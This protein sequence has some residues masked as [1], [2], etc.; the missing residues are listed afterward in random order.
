MLSWSMVVIRGDK[1]C[2]PRLPHC[3]QSQSGG[4]KVC[5]PYWLITGKAS[6]CSNPSAKK[7]ISVDPDSVSISP[8]PIKLPGC[9]TISMKA[10]IQQIDGPKNFFAKVEYT[11]GK[12]PQFNTLACQNA[13]SNGCDGYGNNCYYCDICNSLQKLDQSGSKN[14][15][16][17][18]FKKM[19]C[20]EKAGPYDFKREF[21][22]NDFSDL[23]KDN[24][25]RF[26]FLENGNNDKGYQ[27]ALESL[28]SSGFGTV[29]AKFTLASNATGEQIEKKKTKEAQL[30]AT[31]E[32][33]LESKRTENNWAVDDQQYIT[34]RDWYIKKR[35]DTWHKQD[36]LPWLLYYNQVGCITVNFDVCDKQPVPAT[37][38]ANALQCP[39]K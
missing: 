27:E 21:C 11:W 26:D 8:N 23:D 5:D 7:L 25:C 20:P 4:K 6:D 32:R 22:F 17:S 38:G 1:A 13:S 30:E 18:Q 28:R 10:N 12:V 24:N 14:T 9:F 15:I 37:S 29:T 35:K 33:E 31:I 19:S 39:S 2:D 3:S 36:Y 34:F 16:T